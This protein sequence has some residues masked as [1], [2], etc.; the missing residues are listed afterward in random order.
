M[1]TAMN[2]GHPNE[3]SALD[4]VVVEAALSGDRGAMAKL[5]GRLVPVIRSRVVRVVR[6][7]GHR[8]PEQIRQLSEDLTQEVFVELLREDGRALRGWKPDRGLC[9]EGYVG[10]LATNAATSVMRSGRRSAWREDATDDEALGAAMG[11]GAPESG[12]LHA[13][14]ILAR[15]LPHLRAEL[16]PGGAQVLDLLFLEGRSIEEASEKTGLSSAALYAWRS[17]ITR[18]ATRIAAELERPLA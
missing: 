12:R 6:K 14:D 4:A 16:S 3:E 1:T 18:M 5:V 7:G 9:L 17:R 11:A 15:V 8:T 2:Q 10:L 13:R